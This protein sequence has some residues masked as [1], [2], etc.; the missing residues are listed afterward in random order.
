MKDSHWSCLDIEDEDSVVHFDYWGE[1][2]SGGETMHVEVT[3]QHALG[4]YETLTVLTPYDIDKLID[5]IDKVKV[6]RN[7]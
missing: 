6:K 5:W 4:S 7:G 3:K 1:D 2:N